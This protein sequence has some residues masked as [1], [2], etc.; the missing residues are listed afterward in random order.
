MGLFAVGLN[1]ETAPIE[2]RETMVF[3][4]TNLHSSLKA[5]TQL[6][7]VQ[8]VALLSTC[9]RTEIY[10]HLQPHH[11][12]EILEWIEQR[13]SFHAQISPYLYS[14][15]DRDAVVHM[16]RVA[17]GLNSLVLG[18]PQILGQMKDSHQHATEAGTLSRIMGRLFQHTFKAAK[19]V[20][21]DT[22]IGSSPV[23][24]AFAAVSLAKQIFGELSEQT[25]M[26]IGAGQTIELAARHLKENGVSRIIVANRT[27]ARAHDLADS[28]GGYAIA[29]Q[30]MAAH[31][32]EAD[33][34]ISSTA[35][36]LPVLGK[37]TVES[38]LKKRKHQPIFMVDIAVPRD[39]EPQVGDL[40]DVY[41]YTVDD[42]QGII[43]E[44]Q[45]SREEAAVQAEDIIAQQADDFMRWLKSLDVTPLIKHLRDQSQE[46]R[47]EMLEKALK[48]IEHGEAPSKVLEQLATQLT[49]KL[50][51]TPTRALKLAGEHGQTEVI[52]AATLL[53]NLDAQ[54]PSNEHLS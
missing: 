31:L 25:A 15:H 36:P 3:D 33:I 11:P 30:D 46:M 49:N 34:V 6:T 8:E 29:L 45:K 16:M 21:T 35:S 18:E 32:H 12:H 51:H 5:L 48:A 4:H 7:C 41:L 43:R 42:L 23:S 9:N 39:I 1:H 44:N 13:H 53:F 24:V 10:C 38:A 27:V 2:I 19:Q 28:L 26:V 52:E 14:H 47:D 54:S 20:R 22:S 40:E 37:G 50:I 17:S